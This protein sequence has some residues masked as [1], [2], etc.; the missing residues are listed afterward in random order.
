[1][2]S[3]FRRSN[4]SPPRKGVPSVWHPFSFVRGRRVVSGIPYLLPKDDEEI[5]RLDFQHYMLKG[6]LGGN[7]SAPVERPNAILD[8]ATGTGRWAIEMAR[9][10][11]R[12]TVTGLDIVPPPPDD[13]ANPSYAPGQ[14]PANYVFRQGDMFAGLPF[15]DN[16][17]DFVHQRLVY[18]G[19]PAAKWPPLARELIRVCNYGGWVELVEGYLLIGAGPATT[20]IQNAAIVLS[21]RRGIDIRYGK[22]LGVLAVQWGLKDIRMREVHVPIG[23]QHGRLGSMAETDVLSVF[24]ALGNAAVDAEIIDAGDF[25]IWYEQMAGELANPTSLVVWPVFQVY[26]RK[27]LSK[28]R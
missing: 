16:S 12:A 10:F 27:P 25:N 23:R 9:Q 26:G 1:M 24:K 22:A 13:A 21:E 14:R 11:P 8:V 5:H 20:A 3:W 7:F 18:A 4:S 6:A 17:F 19:V 15:D 2:L 28:Q